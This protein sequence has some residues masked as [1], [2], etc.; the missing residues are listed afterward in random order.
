MAKVS[1]RLCKYRVKWT[2]QKGEEKELIDRCECPE[3][4]PTDHVTGVVLKRSTDCY[5]HNAHGDCSN[6]K[7]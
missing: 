7:R 6:W 1:C 2:V 5:L 4:I 3:F